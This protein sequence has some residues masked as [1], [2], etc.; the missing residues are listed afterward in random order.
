[1][2]RRQSA[3]EMAACRHTAGVESSPGI[4]RQPDGTQL[5]DCPLCEGEDCGKK[6]S[7]ARLKAL[8]FAAQCIDCKRVTESGR[9]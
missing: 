9:Y 5:W 4:G 6:I 2:S 1:M 3:A 7:L 8:P